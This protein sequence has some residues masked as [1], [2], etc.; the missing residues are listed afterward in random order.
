MSTSLDSVRRLF[1]G[2]E[3]VLGVERLLYVRNGGL[4]RLLAVSDSPQ[5]CMIRQT[6]GHDRE[7]DVLVLVSTARG[8]AIHHVNLFQTLLLR[9]SKQCAGVLNSFVQQKKVAINNIWTQ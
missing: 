8:N 1:T 5:T 7:V 9:L 3:V 4:L 2:G 6:F